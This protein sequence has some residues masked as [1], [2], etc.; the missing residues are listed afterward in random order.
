MHIS[1]VQKSPNEVELTITAN[2]ADLSP[3]K[4]RTLKKLAPQVKLAGFREGKT[5]LN[6]VEKNLDQSLFQSEFLDA[7][8]N[9]L[10]NQ[11]LNDENLRP[12]GNPEMSLTKFV[13]FTTLEFTLIV[14][15]IGDIKLPDYKKI[16]LSRIAVKVEAKEVDDVVVSLQK[17]MAER[18]PVGRAAKDGDEVIIDFKGTD[19]KGEAVAG[20]EGKDYP[21]ALGSNS[22][23][24]GFETNVI[25]MNPN[26]TKTFTITFP[27]DYGVAAL[28]SKK[29]TFEVIVRF[30]NDLVEPKA[31]DEFAAKSGPF[32]TM[33]DLKED[34]KKQLMVER[35]QEADRTFEETLLKAIAD[36]TKLNV[37]KQLVDEQI[38]RIENEER[39]NLV[40]RGQTWEEHLSAEGVTAEGHKEQKRPVAEDRVRIGIV[41]SEVAEAEKIVVTPEEFEVR[42]KMMKGQYQDTEAQAELDKPEVQRDILARMMT[43]KT[44]ATLSGY[45]TAK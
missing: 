25:G 19:S 22:F 30:V 12:V 26:E 45:A 21:L 31:D 44:I 9:A 17:R 36:K 20:A 5:P 1:K 43:E 32:K 42:M 24:P 18:K 23:I 6:L 16:K 11:A 4:Q 40:Y 29:V 27:K 38:E 34:I 3:V 33:A 28:Q 13:P 39:Q 2:E 7:A 35:Q 14:P 37:P 41:L 15:V 10:Y 8:V